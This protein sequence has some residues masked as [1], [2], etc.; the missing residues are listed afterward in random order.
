[1]SRVEENNKIIQKCKKAYEEFQKEEQSIPDSAEW[2][3]GLIE[4]FLMDISKSL[5]AIA[6]AGVKTNE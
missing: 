1:M 3:L 5:A 4:L 6:D 2:H